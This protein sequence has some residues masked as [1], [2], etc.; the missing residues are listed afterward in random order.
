[1]WC[2]WLAIDGCWARV[3]EANDLGACARHLGRIGEER[4]IATRLQAMTSGA[5]PTF[6]PP[7]VRV[8]AASDQRE[9]VGS[10]AAA[11]KCQAAAQ[12]QEKAHGNVSAG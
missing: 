5:P 8:S 1:M 7:V 9:A 6:A 10:L 2:G 4:G 12:A 3:C 11:R